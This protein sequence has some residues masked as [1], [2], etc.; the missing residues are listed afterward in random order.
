MTIR[1]K[2]LSSSTRCCT[3]AVS[4]SFKSVHIRYSFETSQCTSLYTP[5]RQFAL[6]T[7][8]RSGAL[9]TNFQAKYDLIKIGFETRSQFSRLFGLGEIEAPYKALIRGTWKFK[10]RSSK[11]KS[12]NPRLSRR[13]GQSLNHRV[14]RNL[15]VNFPKNR[16]SFSCVQL[17][18][19]LQLELQLE[20][21]SESQSESQKMKCHGHSNQSLI[22][23]STVH[24]R[25]GMS[26]EHFKL[27]IFL[28]LVRFQSLH[29][30][31]FKTNPLNLP[32]RSSPD[33][34]EDSLVK[35]RND[36]ANSSEA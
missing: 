2:K 14:F 12:W 28:D 30:K 24:F 35:R 20:S 26:V 8:S 3:V 18:F 15:T 31:R 6:K 4:S 33:I 1:P 25:L 9:K 10:V 5:Q 7:Q 32:R 36:F 34:T 27:Q 11:I 13:I 16:T 29:S 22:R 23:M 21:Q 17:E 19:G